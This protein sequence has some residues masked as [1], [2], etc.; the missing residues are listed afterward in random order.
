VTR[1]WKSD[2]SAA[3]NSNACVFN[4]VPVSVGTTD[5]LNSASEEGKGE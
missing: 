5:E 4:Y 1:V 2:E 3:L